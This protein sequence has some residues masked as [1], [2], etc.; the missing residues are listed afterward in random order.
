MYDCSK[1]V[2]AYHDAL[3]A[4]PRSEQTAMRDRRNSNRTRLRK[5]LAAN[6][7]PA[8][9]EFV[10]QG[11]YAMRTM[12]Q[13][14]DNDYDIDDGVYFVEDDLIGPRG[15][16]MSSR[17]AREMVRD[18]VDDGSF[19]QAPEVRG[20]CVR[21]FY[22]KGYHVDM[23]VYRTVDV[24]GEIWHE[25]AS[26][27]G[28]R[29]SDA[30]DVTQWYDDGL[31]GSSDGTQERRLTRYLKKFARSRSSWSGRM[32]SGFGITVMVGERAWID[33][34]REDRALHETMREIRDR[35]NSDL[36]IDHPV[37]PGDM[38]TSGP[39]DPKPAFLRN[40]LTEAL[41]WLDPLFESD[42][43][44]NKALA[45]WDKVFSTSFFSERG[46]EEARAQTDW[47]RVAA[48]T[49]AALIG[50]E[51]ETAAAVSSSGGGRHA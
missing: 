29:R 31:A 27:S 37:T 20:N 39:E 34:G 44:R 6:D 43:T 22:Q 18:A 49:S 7:D 25:L 38:L 15:G 36:E 46:E 50:L 16:E 30:R 35:L 3:V 21:V 41:G 28:W 5:G 19:T 51:S 2:K 23:P 12:V 47:G 17:Q 11:S 8:P 26:A 10:K 9:N 24:D 48:T 14:P 1:D 32:L 40:K 45:C 4:L 33:S 13:H 42:C